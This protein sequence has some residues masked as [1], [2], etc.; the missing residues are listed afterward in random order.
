MLGHEI[1]GSAS[2]EAHLPHTPPIFRKFQE[3]SQ[4]KI[5]PRTMDSRAIGTQRDHACGDLK[6]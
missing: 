1:E 3:G 6:A 5:D 2:D 4:N